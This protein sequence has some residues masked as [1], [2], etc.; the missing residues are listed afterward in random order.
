MSLQNYNSIK[1]NSFIMKSYLLLLSLV[2]IFHFQGNAQTE[3]LH[4]SFKGG[5]AKFKSIAVTWTSPK[6]CAGLVKYGLDS[7]KLTTEVRVQPK[8]IVGEKNSFVYKAELKNLLPG[9]VYY[10]KCGSEDRNCDNDHQKGSWSAVHSFTTPPKSGAEGK[11][12]IGVWGDTQDNQG[13]KS[14][15]K[16]AKIVSQ[17]IKYPLNLTLHMGDIVENGSVTASWDKFL[18]T[19]EALNA[20]VPFMPVTG[21]HD[22]VNAN[23]DPTFQR[24]FPIFHDL[25]DLPE[26]KL[27]YSFDYGNIHF[28][29][30]NSGY[31]QGA[32]KVDKVLFTKGSPEYNWLENDLIKARKNKKI[33]W[34]I[35]Y[36]H[37][38]V[39]AYGVSLVPQWQ[40]Q[41]SP[42]IDRYKVDLVL[43]GHRHVY[44]R[45]KAIR[46][47][48]PEEQLDF[49]VYHKPAGTVYITNGSAGGSLQGVGGN[50][51]PSMVFTPP[52][53]MHTYA[54][55]TIHGNQLTYD[56]YNEEAEKIDHFKLLK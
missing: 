6:S 19:A 50:K 33:K 41:I 37:Y 32:A 21:N 17:L 13:N 22:V 24:P 14:F 51:M 49:H 27:N 46:N 2:F 7:S 40:D 53:R 15:E 23:N 38:P 9:K 45:H 34:I 43:S 31:C 28:V 35:L 54:V 5:T 30:I 11:F 12:T 20:K 4:L 39:H 1:T 18:Q 10:Y 36:D 29:A 3:N 55:M 44:E 8:Q 16:T 52:T 26:D 48:I 47:N 25:F 56:V 42:I